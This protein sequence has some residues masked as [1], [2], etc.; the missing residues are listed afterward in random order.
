M[1]SLSPA[2]NLR[3]QWHSCGTA[4]SQHLLCCIN[5]IIKIA[6]GTLIANKITGTQNQTSHR[7]NGPKMRESWYN[8]R[9]QL[10]CLFYRAH[11]GPILMEMGT[12]ISAAGGLCGHQRQA[13]VFKTKNCPRRISQLPQMSWWF[14][15][16]ATHHVRSEWI[17]HGSLVLSW[18]ELS[19]LLASHNRKGFAPLESMT[20]SICTL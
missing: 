7:P 5:N 13:R 12:C 4:L 9:F 2:Q 16:F 20:S 1:G 17:F 14:I 19:L 10:S 11:S 18:V 3:F 8:S 15:I 6:V